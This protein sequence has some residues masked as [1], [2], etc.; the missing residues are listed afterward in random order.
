M[1]ETRKSKVYNENKVVTMLGAG[2][3]LV[4]EVSCAGTIRIE[5]SI[6]GRVFS[7]D[8]IVLLDSGAIKGDICAG[9]VIISGEVRGNIKA[10]D[11]L[12]ITS[13]GKVIGDIT[14]PRICIHEGV[15][16]EGLC[17]MRPVEAAAP[18]AAHAPAGEKADATTA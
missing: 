7:E 14:A 10:I 15:L 4:G 16:F 13:H 3:K 2:T 9:Q 5:G 1:L 12:E 11:R 8:S 18:K 17:T 6:E